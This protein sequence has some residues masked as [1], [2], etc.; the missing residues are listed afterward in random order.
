MGMPTSV[1]LSSLDFVEMAIFDSSTFSGGSA[2]NLM[3]GP[4]QYTYYTGSG[5]PDNIKTLQFYNG[6][7]VPVTMSFK[8]IVNSG[9]VVNVPNFYLPVGGTFVLDIQAN[10]AN[11]SAYGSGTLNGR[12]G[13]R[14]WGNATAGTGSIYISAFR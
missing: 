2:Y 13:Q 12:V 6:S 8:Q 11:N 5:F 3:N 4:S 10:H 14:I 7:T 9:S 1:D